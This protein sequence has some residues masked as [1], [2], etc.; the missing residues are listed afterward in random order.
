MCEDVNSLVHRLTPTVCLHISSKALVPEHLPSFVPYLSVTSTMAHP[1]RRPLGTWAHGNHWHFNFVYSTSNWANSMPNCVYSLQEASS[2]NW[3]SCQTHRTPVILVTTW[4][5]RQLYNYEGVSNAVNCIADFGCK[6]LFKLIKLPQTLCCF[7][8]GWDGF[9]HIR[10]WWWKRLASP[11]GWSWAKHYHT[12]A[13]IFKHL[14]IVPWFRLPL[15]VA[16]WMWHM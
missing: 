7:H 2:W 10:Q 3:L 11:S 6:R 9:D 13:I 8:P 15:K 12:I 1:E 14:L 16:G 5:L 4:L